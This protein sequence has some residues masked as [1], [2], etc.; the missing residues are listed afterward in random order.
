MRLHHPSRILGSLLIIV[1]MTVAC[2]V[3]VGCVSRADGVRYD[4]EFRRMVLFSPLYSVTA[5]SEAL[6]NTVPGTQALTP[7][8]WE[9][10]EKQVLA[11]SDGDFE[12]YCRSR[13]SKVIEYAR[14]PA[15]DIR[16][17]W[18]PDIVAKVVPQVTP[19][20]QAAIDTEIADESHADWIHEGLGAISLEAL[21][22]GSN[23]ITPE[24]VVS[25]TG[26]RLYGLYCRIHWEWDSSHITSVLPSSYGKVYAPTWTDAGLNATQGYYNTDQTTYYKWVQWHFIQ[27]SVYPGGVPLANAYPELN[28]EIHAGGS[29]SYQSLKG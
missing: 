26:G 28:I 23:T 21:T 5:S 18:N 25:G 19:E 4:Q 24:V 13:L 17:Q 8:Q 14:K 1:I 9:A 6:L 2:F 12:E 3:P 10:E 29:S 15:D 20:L 16:I 11:M 7:S 27:W 22:P